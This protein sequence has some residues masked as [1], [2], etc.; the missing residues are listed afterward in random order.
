MTKVSRRQRFKKFVNR[1]ITKIHHS[2]YDHLG[3]ETVIPSSSKAPQGSGTDDGRLVIIKSMSAEIGDS[4]ELYRVS[5]SSADSQGSI[6]PPTDGGLV[7]NVRDGDSRPASFQNPDV[8]QTPFKI[9]RLIPTET[10]DEK[11]ELYG[12]NGSLASQASM[13]TVALDDTASVTESV[14]CLVVGEIIDHEGENNLMAQEPKEAELPEENTPAVENT[15]KLMSSEMRKLQKL[16]ISTGVPI[17][18]PPLRI[19]SLG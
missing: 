13:R 5:F 10:N 1:Q 15:E 17:K 12:D 18:K 11:G 8:Q 14:K 4:D 2:S 7:K 6:I 9:T 3:T 16:S 19:L